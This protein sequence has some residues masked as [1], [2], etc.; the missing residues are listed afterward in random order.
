MYFI[1]PV[2]EYAYLDKS[3]WAIR[4]KTVPVLYDTC[5]IYVCRNKKNSNFTCM[6][7]V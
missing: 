6:S 4:K 7:V 5:F 1:R 2:Y 3:V